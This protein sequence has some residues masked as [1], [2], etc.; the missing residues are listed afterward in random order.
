MSATLILVKIKLEGWRIRKPG[1]LIDR[2]SEDIDITIYRKIFG[3]QPPH[4]PEDA[5]R[6]M[7][8]KKKIVESRK[9]SSDSIISLT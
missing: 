6:K 8:R 5:E 2:F 3:Q 1:D 7:Q 4:G 9:S